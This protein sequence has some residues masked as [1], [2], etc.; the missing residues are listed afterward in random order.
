[1]EPASR[2]PIRSRLSNVLRHHGSHRKK[3]GLPPG[4]LVF[5]GD[6]PAEAVRI[7]TMDFNATGVQERDTARFSPEPT[8]RGDDTVS[9]IHVCG[10]HDVDVLKSIG[11]HFDLHPLVLE[12]IA[13]PH[14]RP[15]LE[16]YD[17]TLFLV[18]HALH[19]PDETGIR[20]EQISL[21]LGSSFL[22]S[23]QES[24]NDVFGPIR[25]RV[26][27]GRGRI[28]T[29]PPSYLAYALL[30]LTVDRYFVALESL[31]AES[32]RLEDQI[33]DEPEEDTQPRL[34][35]LRRDLSAMRRLTWPMRD[36]LNQ[37][38]RLESPLWSDDV[39]PFVR[40]VYD[41]AIQVIDLVESQRDVVNGLMDVLMSALS[42]RMN[43]IMKVLTVIGTIF[44]PL[45][46]VVGIYGMNFERMPELGWHYGY[47]ATM[48][49]MALL[50]A[51]LLIY[52]R[53]HDWI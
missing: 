37:L 9:W 43:E 8:F 52:F 11:S 53:R 2:R 23:F 30:D 18:A 13:T 32:E 20:S 28:R 4:T 6:A 22:L 29:A 14:Q 31:V 7:L 25:E 15:K 3:V 27:T 5:T 24:T 39:R 41:H 48:L 33:L 21:V 45:T 19:V 12:D 34:H 17:E 26:R 42:Q 46:F 16:T 38:T 36:L 49:G 10:V 35:A 50:A 1:M 47:P 44:L 51:G 40:D